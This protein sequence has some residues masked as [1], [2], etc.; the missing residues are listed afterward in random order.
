MGEPGA[1]WSAVQAWLLE[2]ANAPLM[3]VLLLLLWLFT[4][5]RRRDEPEG[6]RPRRP[7]PVTLDELGRLAFQAA[8]GR[9]D[10]LWR[11]LFIN[12]AEARTL[13]GDRAQ[14]FVEFRTP[15]VLRSV[16]NSISDQ[17]PLDSVFVGV[18][19]DE[20]GNHALHIRSPTQGER[21]VGIGNSVRIGVAWR[22]VGGEPD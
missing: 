11:G 3:L 20:D 16:M 18:E 14:A 4:L 17:I 9:D 22:L 5:I 8:R 10:R 6:R 15:E 7:E 12:G 19:T 1:A 13:L 2:G 21:R